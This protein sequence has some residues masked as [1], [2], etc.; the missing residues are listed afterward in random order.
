MSDQSIRNRDRQK[1]ET[2][3]RILEA[4]VRVFSRDGIL[5]S[6]TAD[7]AKEAGVSHG[8][9]FARFGTQ[10]ALVAAVIEEI[11]ADIAR[12]IH[13]LASG[14]G[15]REVLAAHLKAIGEQESFFARLV[16]ETPSLP[17]RARESLVMI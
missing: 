11:G 8:S 9:V 3:R 15:V 5:A 14:A 16:A 10:D 4:A 13:E 17:P 12:R 1:L 2:S 7:I 6:I